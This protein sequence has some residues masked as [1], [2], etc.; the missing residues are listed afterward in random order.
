MS[1]SILA[2]RIVSRYF[3]A[4]LFILIGLAVGSLALVGGI[5]WGVFCFLSLVPIGILWI[6]EP[7]LARVLSVGPLLGIASLLTNLLRLQINGP[8]VASPVRVAASAAVL[9]TALLAGV[10]FLANALRDWH[11][12]RLPLVLSITCVALAF[13]SDR[14]F[15]GVRTVETYKMHFSVDGKGKEKF[16]FLAPPKKG[17]VVVYRSVGN[18]GNCFDYFISQKLYDKL[19]SEPDAEVTVQYE[20]TRDFGRVRGYNVLSVDGVDVRG[21]NG[22]GG[23]SMGESETSPECF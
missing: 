23:S 19:A 14:L 4:G 18:G 20:I 21:E 6:S 15:L 9:V 2:S 22:G 10:F 3:P 16:D 13:M 11:R 1:K 7:A 12:R 17:R 5:S 8:W